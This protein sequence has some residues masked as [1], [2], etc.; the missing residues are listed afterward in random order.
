MPIGRGRLRF[1]PQIVSSRRNIDSNILTVVPSLPA[2]N[3]SNALDS[4]S[5]RKFLIGLNRVRN[6]R[7]LI[8]VDNAFV[9][10]SAII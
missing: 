1:N 3:S 9:F 7:G 10:I 5:G 4:V 6:I 2:S 8:V